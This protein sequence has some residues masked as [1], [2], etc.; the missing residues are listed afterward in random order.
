MATITPTRSAPTERH[1]A[2][3]FLHTWLGLAVGDDGAPVEMSFL[4]D[5]TVQV[6]GTFGSASVIIEGSLN[7]TDYAVLTDPQGNGLTV[8]AAKIETIME[9]V[10]YVRPRITGGDGTTNLSVTILMAGTV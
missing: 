1:R 10:A 9:A 8:S 2:V 6:V 7:G 3:T 4:T 5:R